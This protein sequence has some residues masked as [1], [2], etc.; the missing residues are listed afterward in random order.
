[1][2]ERLSVL[3]HFLVHASYFFLIR[4][5]KRA[6]VCVRAQHMY[7]DACRRQ[8][9]L[10]WIELGIVRV[11]GGWENPHHTLWQDPLK[12]EYSC[13]LPKR[14]SGNC[15]PGFF[16]RAASVLTKETSLQPPLL[17]LRNCLFLSIVTH[18]SAVTL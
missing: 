13:E 9:M 16:V 1:M 14:S 12:L 17:L 3:L 18:S 15:T 2:A 7:A 6:C 5:F 10:F 11:P 8:K 4:I